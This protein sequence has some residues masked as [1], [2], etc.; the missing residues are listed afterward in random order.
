M[1]ARYRLKLSLRHIAE[2]LGL[3]VTELFEEFSERP[4]LNISISQRVPI[5]TFDGGQRKLAV[6]EWGFL[7]PWDKSKRIFNAAGE[8]IAIKPTFRE[9]FKDRRCLIPADGFYEWPNKQPTLIHFADD[10]LFCFA[11]L[12]SGNA[13]TMITCAPNDFMRPIHHRM[14][15]ILR[16]DD[17]AAWLDPQSPRNVLQSLI[18]T[19]DWEEMQTV[20]IAKLAPDIYPAAQKVWFG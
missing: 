11:G 10:R 17:Y 14:P 13:M 18:A 19:R 8:T 7:A 3:S 15:A 16:D 2:L 5:V 1:C 9:S 20:A 12:W 4:R 6:A